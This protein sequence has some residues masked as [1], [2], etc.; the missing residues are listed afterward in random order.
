MSSHSLNTPPLLPHLLPLKP[1]MTERGWCHPVTGELLVT[2]RDGAT[3]GGAA[4]VVAVRFENSSYARGDDLK[5][6]VDYNENVTVAA[7][8]TLVVTALG[9]SNITLKAAAQTSV[10]AVVY[11]KQNGDGTTQQTVPDRADTYSVGAQTLGGTIT[12]SVG[13]VAASGTLTL[14]AVP[15]DTETVTID[16]KV[17]TFKTTLT[18][19][20]GFVKRGATILECI[21]NL[22]NAIN[23]GTGAGTAYATSTTLHSTVSAVKVDN[24]VVVTAKTKGTAG[25]SL[26][27]TETLAGTGSEWGAATLAG[28]T[29]VSTSAKTISAGAGTLCGTIVVPGGV[30]QSVAWV[31]DTLVAGNAVGLTVVYDEPVNVTAG[32]YIVINSTT[33]NFNVYAAASQTN[34]TTVTFDKKVDN[35]TPQT[36]P[37][38]VAA[39]ATIT[40]DGTNVTNLD[41]VVVNGKTYTFQDTLT[42]V[43][44]NVKI[45]AS[46]AASLTNLFRAINGTGGVAGTDY[47]L[48]TVAHTTVDAT[49]PTGTTVVVTAKTAGAAGNAYTLTEASTHLTVSGALF[50]GGVT[51]APTS[52][53]VAAQSI[54]GTIVDNPTTTVAASKVITAAHVAEVDAIAIA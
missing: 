36:V 54:T 43:D 9:G 48:A 6:I 2:I 29:A 47:A 28:G 34:V 25:N 32:A 24:T 49:N 7:G 50:T 23:L 41:T 17:Y 33:G 31:D 4:D 5:V 39:A 51:N 8:S 11:S 45:G 35:T 19:T 10:N 15:A 38:N 53:T 1:V 44:G 21:E 37:V 16:S 42:N 14:G 40:G 30:I 20:D 12:D 3:K 27:T 26:G 18:D 22:V 52:L 46:A 13:G